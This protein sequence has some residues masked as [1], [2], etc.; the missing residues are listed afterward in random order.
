MLKGHLIVV[1][2]LIGSTAIVVAALALPYARAFAQSA[3]Y[4]DPKSA[5]A[6][7]A[8][9]HAQAL[10]V[11]PQV[12]LPQITPATIPLLETDP[13]LGGFISTYQPT[14]PTTTATNAY[15]QSLGTNGRTCFT[16]HQPAQDW[17]F[18][19]VSAQARYKQFGSADPLFRM[20]DGANC[21]D[22]NPYEKS[23][24]SQML[25]RGN[26]RIFLPVPKNPQFTI[27]VTDDP[28]GCETDPTY[29]IAASNNVSLYRRPLPASN[30]IF[31]NI[32]NSS[33]A[34]HCLPLPND[35]G[36]TGYT[37]SMT[38]GSNVLT[39]T[40]PPERTLYVSQPVLVA[41]AGSVNP[42][43][44]GVPLNLLVTTV[45]GVTS[46]TVYTLAANALHSVT[47]IPVNTNPQGSV[48]G[49]LGISESCN[50]IMWDGREPDLTSQFI[51]ATLVHAQAVSPP[52]DDQANQGVNFQ[53]GLFTAQSFNIVA[54]S[55]SAHGANGGPLPLPAYYPDGQDSTSLGTHLTTFD[56]FDGWSTPPV[57]NSAVNLQRASIARGQFIFN[58][59][60]MHISGVAGF[61]NVIFTGE[62]FNA[63]CNT[64]HNVK[65]VGSEV[66]LHVV[67][68]GVAGGAFVPHPNDL[69]LFTL[70]CTSGNV[71]QPTAPN[72]TCYD[73]STGRPP[74]PPLASLQCTPES[75]CVVTTDD[76]G[77]ALISGNCNDISSFKT[78]SL[79]GI[80]A[81]APFFH[82]GSAATLTD[83]VNFYNKRFDMCVPSTQQGTC[84][85]VSA[86]L[87]R[88][89]I[90]DLTNFLGS[91]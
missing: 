17:S 19:P 69:P 39:L 81:R 53:E 6:W 46:S 40:T 82:D 76:P 7:L 33:P 71:C 41:G 2:N 74:F 15:F 78:P 14:G 36:T 8:A 51:D 22:D 25:N 85:P 63:S 34:L 86:G 32:V 30:L 66:L 3:A 23:S 58:N 10:T 62:N 55:L 1:R 31:L 75:P 87:S 49:E 65:N 80:V 70:T 13:D 47:G 91:L 4:Q 44:G 38:A 42:P 60:V 20:V 37:G 11:P 48:N 43:N 61:N 77:R 64:C 50:N 67:N 89:N 45:T 18:T 21:P 9:A 26:N 59:V 54:G 84:T 27:S 29:G 12:G 24:F 57:V 28:T 90:L 79:R 68:T 73:S 16:C 56:I 88:Q 72:Q 5:P 35:L 52:T 83:V